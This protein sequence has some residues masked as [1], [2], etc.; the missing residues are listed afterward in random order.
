MKFW[1]CLIMLPGSA[2]SLSCA[3]PDE[4]TIDNIHT[5]FLGQLTHHEANYNV[6]RT[7]THVSAYFTPIKIFEGTVTTTQEFTLHH[8]HSLPIL[9]NEQF[10]LLFADDTGKI[11]P[12]PAIVRYQNIEDPELQN[13]LRAE[14]STLVKTVYEHRP[15]KPT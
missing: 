11:Y 7:K 8:I 4:E 3:I 5:I 12:C 13:L 10:Y 14:P 6:L 15:S 9:I 2:F 1:L